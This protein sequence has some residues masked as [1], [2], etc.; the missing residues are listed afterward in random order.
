MQHGGARRRSSERA[1]G[2]ASQPRD[3]EISRGCEWYVMGMA[4]R[5]RWIAKKCARTA[6]ALGPPASERMRLRQGGRKSQV[7]ALTYHRFG[8]S[9]RD[10]FCVTVE[11]FERQM[12]WLAYRGLPISLPDLE[13]FVERRKSVP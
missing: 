10:P 6:V 7:R 13:A 1:G 4:S 8:G 2:T 12:T 3:R 5:L 11:D 9:R